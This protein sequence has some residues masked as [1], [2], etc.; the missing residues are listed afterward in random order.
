MTLFPD[1]INGSTKRIELSKTF[2]NILG[3]IMKDLK[4]TT[5]NFKTDLKETIGELFTPEELAGYL[6]VHP[7]TIYNWVK[8]GKIE[9][10]VLSQG[11]RKNTVRFD[12]Q[13]IQQFIKSEKK[14]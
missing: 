8:N 11:I 3:N 9:C 5:S 7:V 1:Y 12:T 14:K 4:K 13:Q 2:N 10:Y 6:K